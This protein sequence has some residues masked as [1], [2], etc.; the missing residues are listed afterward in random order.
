MLLVEAVRLA[1]LKLVIPLLN[2]SE[3]DFDQRFFP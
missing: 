2:Y 1:F 3:C